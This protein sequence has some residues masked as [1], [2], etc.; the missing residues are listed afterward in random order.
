[1]RLLPILALTTCMMIPTLATAGDDAGAPKVPLPEFCQQSRATRLPIVQ[2]LTRKW[3]RRVA[4]LKAACSARW[5]KTGAAS[6]KGG[7]VS[8]EMRGDVQCPKGLPPG[9]TK[10]SAWTV[11]SLFLE[12][13]PLTDELITSGNPAT[14][15]YNEKCASFDAAE[16]LVLR[17]VVN[18][19]PGLQ[20]ILAWTPKEDAGAP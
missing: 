5:V 7:R 4:D 6:V 20:R 14:E 9:E 19:R 2:I 15:G 16:G 17:V 10:E 13:A 11:L 12:D 8:P 18:D 1:M 3:L